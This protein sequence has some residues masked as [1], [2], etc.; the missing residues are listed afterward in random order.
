MLDLSQSRIAD[1]IKA[2]L[3]DASPDSSAEPEGDLS[4]GEMLCNAIESKDYEAIKE[5]VKRC[6]EQ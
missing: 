2:K 1:K 4:P 6:N 5:A 3:K